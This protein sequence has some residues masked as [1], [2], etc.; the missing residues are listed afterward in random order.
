MLNLVLGL[1]AI[2]LGIVVLVILAQLV[3]MFLLW[4][5]RKN[6]AKSGFSAMNS[7]LDTMNEVMTDSIES[8][9][10]ELEDVD[11]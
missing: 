1:L 9:E 11:L 3:G 10:P 6:V 8:E 2:I 5:N 7:M 4:R